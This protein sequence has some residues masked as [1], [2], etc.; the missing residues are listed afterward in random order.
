[1]TTPTLLP[2]ERLAEIKGRCERAST[3]KW[4]RERELANAEFIDGV[5]RDIPALL[6]HISALTREREER[7][8]ADANV[9]QRTI[10]ALADAVDEMAAQFKA[11]DRQAARWTK[12]IATFIRACKAEPDRAA[13]ALKE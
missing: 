4:S 6:D 9:A 1:M 7:L 5:R 2:P 8:K 11:K 3:G 10:D 12:D 13:A